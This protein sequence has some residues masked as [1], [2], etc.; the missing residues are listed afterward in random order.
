MRLYPLSLLLLG[1]TPATA[2]IVTP[3]PPAPVPLALV[4]NPLS[5]RATAQPGTTAP[6][7]NA[8]ITLSGD[9]AGQAGWTATTRHSWITVTVGAGTGS[10]TASWTRNTSGLAVGYYVDTIRV[11]A[12]GA[13]GSPAQVIDTLQ[14]T[15]APVPLTM[16]VS[17]LSRNRATT[18]GTAA[19]DENVAITL[20]GDNAGSTTWIASNRKAWTALA[21]SSG[22]SSGVLTWHRNATTLAIGTYVDTITITATGASGSPVNVIDTLRITAAPVPLSLVVTPSSRNATVAQGG[23]APGTTAAVTLLG[24]N[25]ATTSWTVT[26]KKAWTTLTTASGTGSGIAAWTRNALGLVAGTYVDTIV[27][28]AAGASGS[29][30]TV[31]DSLLVTAVS[32]GPTPDL[33]VN[34]SLHG[35]RLFPATDPWNLAVD[36]AEVDPSSAAILANVGVTKSLHPDFGSDP[37]GTFGYSYNIVPDATP[38]TTFIFDYDGESDHVGYPIP[39]NPAIENGGDGH[40]FLITQTE[41]KLYELFDVRQIGGQWFAGSGAVFDLVNGTQRPAGWTS[42]DAAGLPMIPG[43]VRYEEV[44]DLGEITHAL[45]FTI[46]RTQHAYVPPATHWASSS[47]DPTRPPMGMRVRLR[48]NFDISGY[49]APMQVILR[50]LKKYGMMVADNGGDF[51]LSGITDNR[52]D[53]DINNLLKQVKVGDFEVL[54]MTGVVTN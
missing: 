43:M 2:G 34:T 25:A 54:R 46:T 40:M 16:V 10:G 50:A 26:K 11:T 28:T 39:P 36:M 23:T 5:R 31:I 47:T 20:T 4:V 18:Q 48:A 22:T 45:R 30:G 29:P 12:S 38:R 49:P 15:V 37:S 27:V 41:W 51:F 21:A 53:N 9:N 17:P 6:G 14:I 32:T 7:D 24:D 3:P 33:G 35:K 44:Y 1:C 13:T 52:W 19:P 42:A 8:A